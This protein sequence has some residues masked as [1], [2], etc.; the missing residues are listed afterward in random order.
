MGKKY[1]SKPLEAIHEAMKDMYE[2]GLLSDERMR[3]FDEVCLVQPAAPVSRT[4][5][6]EPAVLPRSGTPVYARGK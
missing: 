4:G 2:I 6:Q 3:H 5:A 1:K